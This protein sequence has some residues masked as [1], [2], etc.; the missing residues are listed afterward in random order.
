MNTYTVDLVK[1]DYYSINEE[2]DLESEELREK[3]KVEKEL[4]KQLLLL[5]LT[6]LGEGFELKVTH[7]MYPKFEEEF[8]DNEDK[9]KE[10]NQINDQHAKRQHYWRPWD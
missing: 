10:E 9:R 6:D 4:L 3:D 1:Y 8:R 2:F 5:G 7:T